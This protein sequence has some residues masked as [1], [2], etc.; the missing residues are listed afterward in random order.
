MAA[1]RGIS[2]EPDRAAMKELQPSGGSGTETQLI[3][4]QAAVDQN[5]PTIDLR[6]R[7]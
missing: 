6:A 4:L 2:W 5:A 1:E 3:R 7:P